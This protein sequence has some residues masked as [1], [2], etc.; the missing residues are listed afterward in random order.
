MI[1]RQHYP[2]LDLA[3]GAGRQYAALAD[4]HELPFG[5]EVFRSREEALEWLGF[6]SD[7]LAAARCDEITILRT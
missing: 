1:R 6:G 5:H 4:S 2:E 7:Q 3:F